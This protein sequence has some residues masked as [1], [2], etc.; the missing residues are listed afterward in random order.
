MVP[1]LEASCKTNLKILVADREDTMEASTTVKVARKEEVVG[2]EA[3]GSKPSRLMT[4]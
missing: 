2:E 1:L 4:E 3:S